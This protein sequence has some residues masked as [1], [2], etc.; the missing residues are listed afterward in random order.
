MNTW[1]IFFQI[2]AKPSVS[3]SSSKAVNSVWRFR[4]VTDDFGG[5]TPLPSNEI[6]LLS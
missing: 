3:I 2:G 5:C 1:L 4:V 6:I